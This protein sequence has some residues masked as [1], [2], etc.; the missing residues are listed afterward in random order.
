VRVAVN[1]DKIPVI[2][3]GSINISAAVPAVLASKRK[4][5]I[6]FHSSKMEH[7]ANKAQAERMLNLIPGKASLVI[8]RPKADIYLGA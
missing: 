5:E 3:E 8:G 7:L 1:I 4:A 2:K 6:I